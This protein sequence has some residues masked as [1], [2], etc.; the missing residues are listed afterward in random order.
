MPWTLGLAALWLL[1][2]WP[3]IAQP[4]RSPT[5]APPGRPPERYLLI[6]ETSAAMEK[7]AAN[8][9]RAVGQLFASGLQGQLQRGDTIGVWTY[10]D[11]L[12]T[13]QFPLQ[14]WTSQNSQQVTTAVVQFLQKQRHEKTARL[15]SV[16]TQLT[17]VV[18]DSDRITILLVSEGGEAPPGTPFTEQIREAF[19]LNAAEQRQQ[20]MPFLTVLR[21]VRGEFTGFRVNTPPWPVEFPPFPT[22]MPPVVKPPSAAA[23]SPPIAA[24]TTNPPVTATAA[25]P[26]VVGEKP[27]VPVLDT[28]PPAQPELPTATNEAARTASVVVASGPT[29][30]V[31][32]SDVS[33]PPT[34]RSPTVIP[35]STAPTTVP[36]EPA[37]STKVVGL[38]FPLMPVLIGG[39]VVAVVVVVFCFAL[40]RRTREEPRVSLI[41]QSMNKDKK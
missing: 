28:N 40:F 27:P 11:E 29:P 30:P 9:Q 22:N 5:N 4:S 18:A 23:S 2:T 10:N 7:R 32:P 15:T 8:T 33:P 1:G 16:T 14:R 26:P 13:G 17:N 21:A 37:G 6:V 12:Y 34:E 41:T 20:S 39:A 36:A 25:T 3:L 19:R 31:A 38:K 24:P 35:P